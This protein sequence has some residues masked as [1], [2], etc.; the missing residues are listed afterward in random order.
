MHLSDEKARSAGAKVTPKVI[1]IFRH[2]SK[3]GIPQ[4]LVA[5]AHRHDEGSRAFRYSLA[6][7]FL[8]S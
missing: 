8:L 3:W 5:V 4:E 6:A 2:L 7:A 1:A